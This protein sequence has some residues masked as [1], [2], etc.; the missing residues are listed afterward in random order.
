MRRE[1]ERLPVA[2]SHFRVESSR[3]IHRAPSAFWYLEF[4]LKELLLLVSCHCFCALQCDAS[5]HNIAIGGRSLS[6]SSNGGERPAFQE[7]GGLECVKH[8][9]GLCAGDD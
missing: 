8:P 7:L 3:C 6:S 5:A 9:R 1:C 4:V 2:P